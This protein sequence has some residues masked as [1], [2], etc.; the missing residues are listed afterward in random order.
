MKSLYPAQNTREVYGPKFPSWTISN[1]SSARNARTR[2]FCD[3]QKPLSTNL[4]DNWLLGV[5]PLLAL[6]KK[7]LAK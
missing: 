6:T 1:R 5:D 7:D 2:L 3:C 4:A